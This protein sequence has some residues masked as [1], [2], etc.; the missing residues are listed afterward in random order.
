[1]APAGGARAEGRMIVFEGTAAA[2]VRAAEFEVAS[3]RIAARAFPY[4]G[5]VGT[6]PFRFDPVERRFLSR[7]AEGTVLAGPQKPDVWRTALLRGPAGPVLVG[8]CSKGEEIRGSY[9]AAAEGAR[10]SGR[11]VYL[12][13]PEPAGLPEKPGAAFTALFVWFPGLE[14]PDAP[15]AAAL[16]RGIPSG[17]ILPL[18]AGW[19][20]TPD[21]IEETVA[22]AAAGGALFLAPVPLADDGQ[23]RRVAV[24]AACAASPE[25][26]D[27]I[28]E[29][30]HH[31]GSS[32]EMREAQE[33]LWEACERAGMRPVPTRP[34]GL[35][36][37]ANN[38]AAAGRLEEKAQAASADEH[39]A[40]LL[41]AA[42]R[43]ID[44]SGR[45]LASIA[46][47]GNFARVFPFGAEIARE[48]EE[49][50]VAGVR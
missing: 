29:R 2:T 10:M 16:E 47:E 46:R 35:R 38:A 3:R 37:P 1:M 49:A 5:E 21:A 19:T 43:W 13:D 7:A 50:L 23:V 48:A 44:E 18:V 27:G 30:V 24:E 36:E 14:R 39:R 25:A 33:R 8:P 32:D 17:W 41:H 15:L 28:F 42:A 45:D 6:S 4:A 22:A 12:L 11:A 26:A 20:A 9:L 31:G 40:A 34:V